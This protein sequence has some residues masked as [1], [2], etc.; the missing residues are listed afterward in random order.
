MTVREQ[1]MGGWAEEEGRTP[2]LPPWT[3][4]RMSLGG[5][6]RQSGE[7]PAR[8]QRPACLGPRLAPRLPRPRAP[9]PGP[10]WAGLTGGGL[11]AGPLLCSEH[12]LHISFLAFAHLGPQLR[13]L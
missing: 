12:W 8:G 7:G 4:T 3:E 2:S 9:H 5:G 6:W 13:A 11:R 10:R 1:E